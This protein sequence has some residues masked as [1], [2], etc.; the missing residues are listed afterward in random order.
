MLEADGDEGSIGNE[1]PTILPGMSWACPH[2]KT[3]MQTIQLQPMPFM[4]VMRKF[5]AI[6]VSATFFANECA[7]PC[8]ASS[9]AC[10]SALSPMFALWWLSAES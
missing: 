5:S 1:I 10:L 3:A 2:R 7:A 6:F 4:V 9:R 8:A